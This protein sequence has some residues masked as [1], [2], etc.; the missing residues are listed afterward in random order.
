MEQ[1]FQK[2]RQQH[3]NQNQSPVQKEHDSQNIVRFTMEVYDVSPPC[4]HGATVFIILP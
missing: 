3:D 2:T 4:K 1:T